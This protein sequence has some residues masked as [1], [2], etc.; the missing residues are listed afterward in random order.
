M[1][2]ARAHA[3]AMDFAEEKVSEYGVIGAAVSGGMDSMCMLHYLTHLGATVVA[4]TV[5]HGIR[6]EDSLEDVRLV[7]DY[8]RTLGVRCV[9]RKVDVPA[10]AAEHRMGTE[11]AARVLRHAFFAEMRR[12]GVVDAIATAHHIDDQAES[13]V[14]NV[15]RG[16][17]LRGLA[18]Q[19]NREGYL[20]PFADRTR[21]QIAAY[22]TRFSVP[23]REDATNLDASY[24]RNFLRLEVLPK[25]EKR[26][27]AYRESLRRLNQVAE[28]QIDL[29]NALAVRPV[30]EK[31]VVY[32]PLTALAQ[33]VALAKWS[34]AE[35]LRRFDY[36]I[37]MEQKHYEAV[38]GLSTAKNNGSVDLPHGVKAA[39]ENDRV[40]FW[41]QEA[42]PDV[43]YPFGEGRFAFGAKTYR[44]R[45]YRE[46]DRLRFDLD[47]IP[48]GAEIRLR[49]AGDVIDKF[50]GGSK[51]LGDYYTDKKV[52]L[53][54]RDSYPVVAKNDTIY[55]CAADISRTVA[56]DDA[57]QRIFTIEED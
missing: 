20:R 13:T 2:G 57:T 46:G 29:L 50:G 51:S 9:T 38:L 34:V 17:G 32:L 37:D 49:R 52:P 36:G 1:A 8:C 35:A 10:Y 19:G 40:A 23:Y 30:V 47:K 55:V 6:G 5:E 45:P 24:N 21:S 25:I 54:I 18:A 33:H 41:R 39:K 16:T 12:E 31:D 3:R 53:R 22:A 48:Q 56:V 14:L 43:R 26:F 42:A 11:E 27:P 28:E 7:E 15:L 44:V 4:L